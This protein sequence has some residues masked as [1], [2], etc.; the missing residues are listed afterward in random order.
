MIRR[1][2][3]V[4]AV[5]LLV[6]LAAC[7]TAA[8]PRATPSPTPPA[9]PATPAAA[10]AEPDSIRWVRSAA[11]YRAAVL[12]A[13]R[14]ALAHVEAAAAGR[15]AGSWAVVLDAD[16]TIISNLTYQAERARAGLP[17]SSDSWAAWVRRREA[18]PLPGAAAFLRRVR[19]L[20]GKV[21]VVTNRLGSE[22]EDTRAVF[23]AHA[24]A[25]DAMLCRPNGSPSDKN[26]RFEQ[27]RA[28]AA[29]GLG[30]P[31][32]IVA[33]LGDNIQDFPGLGQTV[34]DAGEAGFADFGVR[35]FVIPNPM[36]G[37][38]Q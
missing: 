31:L 33:F 37:S 34:K 15:T 36:Y 3:A 18:T 32:E 14:V 8:P 17:Y 23:T 22:C 27:V 6:A 28:G 5:A 20:G 19:A 30:A 1:P 9:A 12:Q 16:E 4:V 11:E 21:A 2:P 38:W 7:R 29:P 35:Y 10:V 26:P 25:Y 13:Y 24:L